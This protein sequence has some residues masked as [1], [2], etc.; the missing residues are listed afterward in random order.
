MEKLLEE[1]SHIMH[2]LIIIQHYIQT[3]IKFFTE[4][5]KKREKTWTLSPAHHMLPSW[6]FLPEVS[7]FSGGR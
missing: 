7:S 3:L 4:L 1:C 2:I 5:E 6:H